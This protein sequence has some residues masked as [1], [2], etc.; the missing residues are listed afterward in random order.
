MQRTAPRADADAERWASKK[1]KGDE[2]LAGSQPRRQNLLAHR[3]AF[4]EGAMVFH[5][6]LSQTGQEPNQRLWRMAFHG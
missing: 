1:P 2:E 6:S 5:E 4:D 3:S